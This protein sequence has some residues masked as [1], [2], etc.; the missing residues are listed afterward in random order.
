MNFALLAV[1]KMMPLAQL[2]WTRE[3]RLQIG[4]RQPIA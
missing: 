4:A 2:Q 3:R 1:Q